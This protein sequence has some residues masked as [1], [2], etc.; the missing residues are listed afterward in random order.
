M[1]LENDVTAFP[2]PWQILR[3]QS[4]RCSSVTLTKKKGDIEIGKKCGKKK[5]ALLFSLIL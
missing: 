3:E 2:A 4:W 5:R 1:H